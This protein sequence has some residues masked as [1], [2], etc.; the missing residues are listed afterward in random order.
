MSGQSEQHPGE[1]R[2]IRATDGAALEYEVVGSGP[3]LVMLHGILAGRLSFSRQRTNFSDHH[4]LIILSARGHDGSENRLPA[5]YGAGSSGVDDLCAVLDAEQLDRVS[6][7]GHSAGGVTAFMFACRYPDRVARIVI[8]E[9]TLL[10]ILPPVDRAPVVAAHEAIAAAAEA[11]GPE[12]GVRA[13]LA[14]VGGEAWTKLDAETQAK[15]LRPLAI[16]SPMVGPHARG[17]LDLKLTEADVRNLCR[18]ALL[19]HGTESA[20]F[21]G[22]IA[23]RFRALRPDFQVIT[24]DGAGHNVHRDRPDIVNPVTL[25]FLAT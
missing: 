8:I 10:H 3:P 14:S 22:I 18:P 24:V 15:R 23:N 13:L 12:A 20:P 9:P 4:R 25:S 11:A 6:L 16:S 19:F 2:S 7:F 1:V 5:N 17:L 21:E